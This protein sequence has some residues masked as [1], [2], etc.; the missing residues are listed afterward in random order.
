MFTL[1][2]V[3]D[4]FGLLVGLV[5]RYTIDL[6]PYQRVYDG[7]LFFAYFREL[8]ATYYLKSMHRF[9]TYFQSITF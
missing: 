1:T 9:F 8:L 2:I 5:E 7:P 6:H 3:L 4:V